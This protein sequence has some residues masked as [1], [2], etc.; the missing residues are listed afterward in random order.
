MDQLGRLRNLRLILGLLAFAAVTAVTVLLGH[1]RMFT[2][3]AGYDDEGYMLIALKSFLSHGNLYDD[4]FSQYG[5]FYYE[6]WGAFFEIFGIPVNHDGGRTAALVAWVLASLLFGLATWRMTRSLLLG[7]VTQILVFGAIVTVV[8]EPMHPGGI[9]CLLLGVIAAF[10]SLVRARPSPMTMALLGGA[11]M[12][13]ILV[14]I[15]VGAFALI[16]LALICVVSY[17]ELV[18]RRWLR[19]LVEVLFIA[20][21]PLLMTSKFGEPWARHYAVHVSAAAFAL[22]VALR[23]RDVPSRPG[24]ELG[25]LVGGLA[26]VGITVCAAIVAAG[27]SLDGLVEGLIQ[28]PLH[29]SSAFSTPMVLSDR[30]YLFD[31]VAV[32]GALAYW[33]LG[34]DRARTASPPFTALISIVSIF[35]GLE[36]AA[37][38]IGRNLALDLLPTLYDKLDFLGFAWVALIPV[39]GADEDAD[40]SFPRLLMPSLA[41]LQALHAFPVAGSQIAWS[42]FLLIPVGAICVANGVR[43]LA[44]APFGERERRAVIAAGLVTA[45]VALVAVFN[46]Q[47]RLPLKEYRAS[48]DGSVSLGLPGAED[49]H[50]SSEE[51]ALYQQVTAAIDA[52]CTSM[53]MLPGLN[54]FYFWSQE[55]PPTG[56]NAT[57]WLTLF[58]DAHQERVI[59]E[60]R[61]IRHLCLLENESAAILWTAGAPPEGPL[62]DYLHTGFREIGTFGNYRLLRREGTAPA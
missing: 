55:E 48:Y 25:W 57:A 11:V 2:G 31:L 20:V 8:N 23:A 49:V 53:L 59:D 34:R 37:S 38:A 61:S 1:P 27:T 54:S 14:K 9:I 10:A 52:N 41:V 7:L 12:A 45:A 3:F 47:V 51:A 26:V 56:F 42:A 32:A 30:T 24:E 43:G 6:F 60:T 50:L 40:T 4:V 28:Q 58:D 39:L 21:P 44:R 36:L 46:V 62:V 17:P 22:V 5:P 29:Q 19:P 18:R 35:V 16:S 15:N 33:R 13:L